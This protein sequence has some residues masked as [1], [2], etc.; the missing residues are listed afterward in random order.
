[1]AGIAMSR[2]TYTDQDL[3]DAVGA[4]RNV[5][6]T[7][8]TLG[9]FP[10]G[11]NYETVQERIRELGL[12]TSHFPQRFLLNRFSDGAVMRRSKLSIN[13]CVTEEAWHRLDGKQTTLDEAPH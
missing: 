5:A 2:R 6:E 4:S 11:G 9:L 3:R 1:M 8:R 12:D 10:G 13:R 7:L